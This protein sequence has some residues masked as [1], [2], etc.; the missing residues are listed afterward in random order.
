M[1]PPNP[2]HELLA[3]IGAAIAVAFLLLTLADPVEA[4]ERVP[5]N[6]AAVNH[7]DATDILAACINEGAVLLQYG[8]GRA[9][10]LLC[11]TR[12]VAPMRDDPL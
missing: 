12:D 4:A 6:P 10:L 3:A 1:T 7:Y 5:P 8:D 2:I 11:T 9:F